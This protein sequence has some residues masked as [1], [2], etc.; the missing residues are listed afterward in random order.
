MRSLCLGL[1]LFAS[2]A[3]AQQIVI[4][5]SDTHRQHIT[6]VQEEPFTP[7]GARIVEVNPD[8]IAPGKCQTGFEVLTGSARGRCIGE[9]RP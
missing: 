8:L 9:V 3:L 5:A 2:P 4:P 1:V 7:H 6:V